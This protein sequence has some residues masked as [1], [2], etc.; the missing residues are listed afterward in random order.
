MLSSLH[1]FVQAAQNT[2]R[3]LKFLIRILL[4]E[5]SLANVSQPPYQS[6]NYVRNTL[7]DSKYFWNNARP[8]MKLINLINKCSFLSTEGSLVNK[9]DLLA[10]Y[11]SGTY[12]HKTVTRSPSCVTPRQ[13]TIYTTFRT[14]YSLKNWVLSCYI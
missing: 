13:L 11:L 14:K 1:F 3:D 8:E 10:L 2:I 6:K 5:H 7:Y 12:C 9:R 4:V